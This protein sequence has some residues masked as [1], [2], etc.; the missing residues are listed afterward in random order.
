MPAPMLQVFEPGAEVAPGIRSLAAYGHTPGH[1]LFELTSAGQGF[2]YVGDLANVPALFVRNPDWAVAFDM[3]AE[4]ARRTRR[5]V[6]QRIVA[7][8]AVVGG[9]HFPFPALGRIAAAGNGYVFQPLA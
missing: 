9:F 8:G 4:A 5:E 3:D 6:L 7:R 1:T 2:V